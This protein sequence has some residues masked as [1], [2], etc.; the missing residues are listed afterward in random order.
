RPRARFL[1]RDTRLDA[2]RGA[3][4]RAI[5]LKESSTIWRNQIWNEQSRTAEGDSA[6][7]DSSRAIIVGVMR[8]TGVRTANQDA[9]TWHCALGS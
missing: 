3:S 6:G 2:R 1:N 7:G 5:A 9:G 4:A 8:L